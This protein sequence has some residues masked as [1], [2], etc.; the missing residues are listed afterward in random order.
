MTGV[1]LNQLPVGSGCSLFEFNVT[2]LNDVG[3]STAVSVNGTIPISKSLYSENKFETN[4]V[5]YCVPKWVSNLIS[6]DCQN[7]YE[8]NFIV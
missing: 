5:N 2:A 1:D 7:C 8:G 6:E 3:N 4:N